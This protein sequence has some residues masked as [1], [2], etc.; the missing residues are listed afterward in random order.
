MDTPRTEALWPEAQ[1]LDRLS[2]EAAL[3]RM[4]EGQIA[5]LAALRPA[6]PDLARA[7]AR[8]AATL[9]A[10]GRIVHAAAGSSALMAL[11]DAAE[12]PGTFGL[13][14]G[15]FLLLMAGGVPQDA[16][17]P[18]DTEDDA[19]A[20]ARDAEQLRAGDLVVALSASGTTP[21]PLDLAR[22]ARARGLEVIALAC[23]P[24]TPLLETASLPICL[25]TPPEALAG[26]TRLGAGTAQK[27]ALNL[28]STLCGVLMGHVHDGMMVNV[29]ADNAK[30]RSRA[31]GI[32]ARIAGVDAAAARAALDRTDGAVKPA[33]L[34]A[35]GAPTPEAAARL[36][37]DSR[38][39]LGPALQHLR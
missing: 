26:S 24:G 10:G 8:M 29:R 7:A 1:P 11:A 25:P 28:M 30:L 5:A 23:N 3:T 37:A 2:P 13:P 34:L 31:E 14:A 17:M 16:T 9:E 12:Q 18:G 33:V 39:H 4:L 6:L 21:Y 38:G 22:R 15:A 35:A 19:A 20:A 32:V 36:L 27:A